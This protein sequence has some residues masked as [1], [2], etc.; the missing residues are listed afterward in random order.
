MAWSPHL[1]TKSWAPKGM[2][3]PSE[4]RGGKGISSTFSL[5]LLCKLGKQLWWVQVLILTPQ[6]GL[7]RSYKPM[8]ASDHKIP[9]LNPS[10]Y[11]TSLLVISE[12]LRFHM[13]NPE[14]PDPSSSLNFIQCGLHPLIGILQVLRTKILVS[15]LTPSLYVMPQIQE[16]IL[17]CTFTADPEADVS[18]LLHSC[19][20]CHHVSYGSLPLSPPLTPWLPRPW[21]PDY[22]SPP[23]VCYQNSSQWS[24]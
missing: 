10:V 5:T 4:T 18:H 19:P 14:V 20:S 23:S 21:L 22:P 7:G 17:G 12:H 2:Q 24:C 15:T 11:S 1:P 16:Q 3:A 13:C 6:T 9:V 8:G